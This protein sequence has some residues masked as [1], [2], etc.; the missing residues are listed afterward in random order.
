MYLPTLRTLGG[1][2]LALLLFSASTGCRTLS[3]ESPANG[4]PPSIERGAL[5]A[6]VPVAPSRQVAGL[7]TVR[8]GRFDSGKMWTFEEAPVDYWRQEYDLVVDQQWLETA[9]LGALRIPGCSASLV[10]ATGLVMT[11]HHCAR[12]YVTQASREGE[13]L[14][15][16]GYYAETLADERPVNRLYADRLVGI[17]DVSGEVEEALAGSQTVAERMAARQEV[18]ASI[19]QRLLAEAGSAGHV[20]EVISLYNGG[21]H[22]A[23]TFRR[24]DDVRLVMA[25]ELQLGYFGGDSDNFTYPRY[26]LDMAFLRIY[27]GGRPL[28]TDVFFPWSRD[29]VLDGMVVFV[30]GNPGSTNRLETMAQL[31]YRRDVQERFLL[32]HISRAVEAMQRFYDANPREAERLGI[33]NQMFSLRNAQKL[34]IGRLAGLNEPVLMAR[35]ADTERQ[36]LEGIL[37]NEELSRRFG[38]LVDEMA[39]LQRERLRMAA[40][41]GAFMWM[42][43]ASA[44]TSATLRRAVAAQAYLQARDGGV[45]SERLAE[46]RRSVA[47]V[48][49]MPATLDQDLLEQR[50]ADFPRYFGPNSAM[51]R[52]V[53]DGQTPAALAHMIMSRS[54][55]TDSLATAR[56]IGEGSVSAEDP[57]LRLVTAFATEYDAYQRALAG[58]N[59]RQAAVAAELGSARFALY[60]TDI[61]PDATFSLRIAD[62]VVRGYSFNGT[63]APYKTNFYGLYDRHYSHGGTGEWALPQRWLEDRGLDLTTPMNI[64]STNDIIGGNSGSPLLNSNLEIVGLVFDGNIESLPS[65]FIYRTEAARAVSVDSRGMLEALDKIYRARRIVEEIRLGQRESIARTN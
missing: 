29:G 56:A 10:S 63:W 40:E 35:R 51:A 38:G 13:F 55:F 39:S 6:T 43:P 45:S 48:G 5:P 19:R 9:R 7:D 23:Y 62:G 65:S 47:L 4:T 1:F 17:T 28:V 26:A 24:Y 33:R 36:F 16:N 25:P 15:D 30:V 46:L 22:S 8:A 42:T 14:L 59:A 32:D 50:I 64:V 57:G 52:R 3:P 60:G 58:L 54:V 21:R 41:Y 34:Y 12:S 61:P 53:L 20:V 44:N 49:R 2:S 37:Q 31:E 11:N 27:D 18:F